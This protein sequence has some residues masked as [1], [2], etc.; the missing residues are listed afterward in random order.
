MRG[1]FDSLNH[2]FYNQ[3]INCISI[4]LF[5]KYSQNLTWDCEAPLDYFKAWIIKF[6]RNCEV[7]T[8]AFAGPAPRLRVE[9]TTRP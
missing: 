6:R 4:Q 3:W 2:A 8:I 1:L 7:L 9:A 5:I